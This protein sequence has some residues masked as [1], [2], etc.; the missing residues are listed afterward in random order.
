M[1]LGLRKT[2]CTHDKITV[3]PLSVVHHHHHP[4]CTQNSVYQCLW[5][6]RIQCSVPPIECVQCRFAEW[7][8]ENTDSGV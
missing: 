5:M 4:L 3:G 2:E 1:P 7:K 6:H 8:K